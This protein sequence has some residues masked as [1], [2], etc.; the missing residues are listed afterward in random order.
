[1]AHW[2]SPFWDP[3]TPKGPGFQTHWCA[4]ETPPGLLPMSLIG[5]PTACQVGSAVVLKK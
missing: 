3:E 5:V 1:M 4:G 2:Y